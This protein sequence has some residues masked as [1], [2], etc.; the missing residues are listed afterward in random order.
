M[1]KR[2]KTHWTDLLAFQMRAV[3]LRPEREYYFAR[4]RKWRA[5]FAFPG[6]KL[7]I[8]F[9]GGVFVKGRHTRGAGFVADCEKYNAAAV[10][11]FTV[12]RFTDKHVRQ[13]TAITLI[14]RALGRS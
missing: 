2:S 12:L 14:E 5:D 10:L 6:D 8:E 9:E 11:G 4:P 1:S 7:L 3:G 13:G